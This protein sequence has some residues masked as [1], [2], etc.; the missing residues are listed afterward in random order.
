MGLSREGGTVLQR[1]TASK[2][3]GVKLAGTAVA[4]GAAGLTTAAKALTI[5]TSLLPEGFTA[6]DIQIRAVG[7]TLT[8]T[9]GG[10][11]ITMAAGTFTPVLPI[12]ELVAGGG[13]NWSV[14]AGSTANI[15]YIIWGTKKSDRV[16]GV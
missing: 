6:Y 8:L 12:D 2:M 15:E 7:Q 11:S 4:S 1:Y 16:N 5:D 10:G 14:L 9:M 13:D 3:V